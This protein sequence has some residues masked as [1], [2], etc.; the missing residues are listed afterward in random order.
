VA[1]KRDAKALLVTWV[2][3]RKKLERLYE[4]LTTP[5]HAGVGAT[6]SEVVHTDGK[7]R[8]LRLLDQ[9]NSPYAGPPVLFVSA[10]VSRYFVLDLMPG[11]SFAGHVAAAG[12]DVFLIDFGEPDD[13]DRY[14]D[15]DYYV[16]GLVGRAIRK[17]SIL[18]GDP[19]PAI[20]GY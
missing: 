19:A 16:N 12:F 15:L 10:P 1:E 3:G 14:A 4:V 20:A 11:R 18:T 13:A 8:L 9:S 6:P 5:V 2:R 7:L 17:I